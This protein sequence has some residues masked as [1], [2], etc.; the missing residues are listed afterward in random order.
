MKLDGTFVTKMHVPVSTTDHVILRMSGSDWANL[1]GTTP[2]SALRRRSHV[3]INGSLLSL[4]GT[5][6]QDRI[7]SFVS[8]SMGQ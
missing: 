8:Q 6:V 3:L 4:D 7:S 1:V 2:C 5:V